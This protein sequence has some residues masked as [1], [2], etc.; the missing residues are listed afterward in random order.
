M[1]YF[2]LGTIFGIIV[3]TVGFTGLAKVA[4]AGVSKV[5]S[6]AKESAGVK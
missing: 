3:N 5:Q 2:I 4:D 1:K 6:V